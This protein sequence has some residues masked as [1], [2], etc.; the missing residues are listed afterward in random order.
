MRLLFRR[1][2]QRFI[3]VLTALVLT[4]GIAASQTTSKQDRKQVKKA[5]KISIEAAKV[6]HEI[7]KAPDRSIPLDLLDKAE[8]VA[9]FPGVINAAFIFGGR[10]GLGVISRRTPTGWSAPAFFKI[11][12]GSFGL[13]I[14]GQ[15]IDYV[16]LV[17]TD[18]G[19]AGLLAKRVELGGEMS[20]AAG[21]VGRTASASTIP[22]LDEGILSYSRTKGLFAGISLKGAVLSPDNDRNLA[23]YGQDASSMLGEDAN[24]AAVPEF[25]KIVPETL[26]LYKK[27]KK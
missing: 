19:L 5:E 10:G 15:E 1:R 18:G 14:G 3:A 4:A 27:K 24:K 11:G 26:A 16:M 25:V 6:F 7:M 17:M 23:V 13:Q 20:V 21:P 12:G 22:T 8:A 2:L 9:I